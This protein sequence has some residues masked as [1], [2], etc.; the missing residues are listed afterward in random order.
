MIQALVLPV[1]LRLTLMLGTLAAIQLTYVTFSNEMFLAVN[2][3]T[4][5]VGL[6]TA[7]SYSVQV[8]I[9][10][11]GQV[12][13]RKLI[14]ALAIAA[15][16]I[17]GATLIKNAP[18]SI[19]A[20]GL[21]Y[22]LYR[23]SDRLFFN[24]LITQGKAVRA[25]SISIA[26]IAVEIAVFYLLAHRLHEDFARLLIPSLLAGVVLA[27]LFF[28]LATG[29]RHMPAR[30][31]S[32][33]LRHDLLFA[34]HSLAILFVV[35]IDRV[36]PSLNPALSY[37]DARYLLMFSYAGAV[38]SIGVA[39]LEPLRPRYFAIAK[40]VGSFPAF[41]I[42]TRARTLVLPTLGLT[43]FGA[44]LALTVSAGNGFAN[45]ESFSN[46]TRDVLIGGGLL[47][48]FSLFLLLAYVQMYFLSRREFRAV[49]LSW[50]AAFAVRL[51][52]LTL[53]RLDLYLAF[54]G[55]AAVSAIAALFIVG[56]QRP[57]SAA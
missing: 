39:V 33:D 51:V 40:E 35:M 15:M 4:F 27:L 26:A 52:A 53:P 41:L 57:R 49:F 54:S 48:F 11:T 18:L 32:G 16:I 28:L 21:A 25:Y 38:Y 56:V 5:L 44:G 10:E 30:P 6:H 43:I 3:L 8:E 1:S 14:A 7:L 2:M 34:S 23:F 45:P 13:R 22:L 12:R 55:L 42:A 20:G 17:A 36:A 24:V 31:T 50:A 19:M 29:D 37:I 46:G 47:S 9:W